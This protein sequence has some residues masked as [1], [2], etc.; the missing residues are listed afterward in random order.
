MP[1]Q[2]QPLG[3]SLDQQADDVSVIIVTGKGG[4]GKSTIGVEE[5]L[6]NRL[7][8]MIGD[9]DVGYSRVRPG[10]LP[11]LSPDDPAFADQ[12]TKNLAAVAQTFG[13]RQR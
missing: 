3:D 1:L 10:D 6:L 11:Q 4:V 5:S 12:Q 2:S 7:R 9:A 13:L 8:E